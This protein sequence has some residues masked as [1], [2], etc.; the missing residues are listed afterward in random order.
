MIILGTP[1]KPYQIFRQA[2]I[3]VIYLL[4]IRLIIL[5]L[6]LRR[7]LKD[8]KYNMRNENSDYGI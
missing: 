7:N 5:F 4:Q 1:K 2:P 8:I 3:E 6:V